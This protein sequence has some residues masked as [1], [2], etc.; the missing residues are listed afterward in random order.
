MK[1][2]DILAAAILASMV[3]SAGCLGPD[4][5]DKD[6]I[7]YESRYVAMNDLVNSSNE[8]AF[9]M[10]RGLVNGTDNVFFSPY[11]IVI[12]LGMAYEGARG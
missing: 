2:V 8:F 11:S 7:G 12:A 5:D 4:H 10:Y 6:P 1:T 3:F 9:R